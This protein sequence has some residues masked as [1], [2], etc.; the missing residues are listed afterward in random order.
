M[1]TPALCFRVITAP[2]PTSHQSPP[3]TERQGGAR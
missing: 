3:D 1:G 2:T